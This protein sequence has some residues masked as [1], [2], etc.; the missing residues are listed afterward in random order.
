MKN[1]SIVIGLILTTLVATI[2]FLGGFDWK[3]PAAAPRIDPAQAESDA[4]RKLS[5][6]KAWLEPL[7]NHPARN[8][9]SDAER[10]GRLATGKI[11]FEENALR[12]YTNSV[13]VLAPNQS[14][15]IL[16]TALS[17]RDEGVEAAKWHN[18]LI[19]K[20]RIEPTST[21]EQPGRESAGSAAT[22][23]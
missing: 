17:R 10:I 16:P 20:R 23:S 18:Q 13:Q 4:L 1:V 14:R 22:L 7:L 9:E 5:A 19:Q 8:T 21:E 11:F 2:Y 12:R 15:L 6:H 3:R